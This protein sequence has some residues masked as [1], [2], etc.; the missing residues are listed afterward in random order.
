MP[1]AWQM[2]CP[3]RPA[4]PVA[5]AACQAVLKAAGS[6][7]PLPLA[8]VCLLQAQEG[9]HVPTPMLYITG[10]L[11]A[12]AFLPPA[13][14]VA[15]FIAGG[16]VA[17]AV[18]QMAG[19]L[20]CA[21]GTWPPVLPGISPHTSPHTNPHSPSLAAWPPPLQPS[22]TGG[23]WPAACLRL[24]LGCTW[25]GRWPSC[26]TAAMTGALRMCGR[27]GGLAGGLGRGGAPR[28]EHRCS[29]AI[30]DAA[31]ALIACACNVPP[32][33]PPCLAACRWAGL[34][35]HHFLHYFVTLATSLHVCYILGTV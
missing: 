15:G 19:W 5:P 3:L 28:S 31:G 6:H 4:A 18:A 22:C 29:C 2:C 7:S 20:S 8:A 1:A 23:A 21:A 12:A 35:D 14:R 10:G 13:P 34:T 30:H 17:G 32:C 27:D 11:L 9:G 24:R 25:W 16:S 33:C 26:A